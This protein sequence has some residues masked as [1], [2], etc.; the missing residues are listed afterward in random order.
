M[1]LV[2]YLQSIKVVEYGVLDIVNNHIGDLQL[3]GAMTKL[4]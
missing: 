2:L 4:K 3:L 1:Y